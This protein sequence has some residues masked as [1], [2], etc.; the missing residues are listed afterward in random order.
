MIWGVSWVESF[1]G[2]LQRLVVL[3]VLQCF[4]EVDARFRGMFIRNTNIGTEW[5]WITTTRWKGHQTIVLDIPEGT[6][7][8]WKVLCT[9]VESNEGTSMYSLGE[10]GLLMSKISAVVDLYEGREFLSQQK[11]T[12]STPIASRSISSSMEGGSSK[13]TYVVT[14]SN[15]SGWVGHERENVE[16]TNWK[17]LLRCQIT[18]KDNYFTGRAL[19]DFSSYP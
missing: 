7:C 2:L 10:I 9:G 14:T 18:N 4:V 15:Y 11:A 5:Q 16:S 12:N 17:S 3:W 6:L 1:A 19:Y 13:M 8:S